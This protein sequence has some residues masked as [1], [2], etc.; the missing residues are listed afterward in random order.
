MKIGFITNPRKNLIEEIE[1]IGK[2][3]FDLVDLFLEE[4][5]AVPE[6]INIEKVRKIIKKYELDVMGHTA[7][8]L[9]IGCPIK[10][11]R[12]TV[13]KEA[14]RYFKVFNKLNVKYVTIHGNWPGMLFSVDE[15]IDFQAETLNRLVKE[16]KKYN[17]NIMYEPI[18]KKQ[19]SYEAIAKILKKVP[20]MYLHLDIGHSNLFGRKPEEYIKRFHKKLKHIH[21]HDNFGK[22]DNHLPIGK[23][24]INWNKTIKALKK[25]YN[26]TISLEIFSKDNKKDSLESRRR[27]IKLWNKI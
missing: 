3:K 9:A 24:S 8:Y 12:E 15:G 13:I 27:L 23:G 7:W 2:N 5:V 16:G 22:E 18:G 1:W 14:I 6:K 10:S 17:V 11:F 19:E 20:G 4:D 26:G 21:M 25:Y